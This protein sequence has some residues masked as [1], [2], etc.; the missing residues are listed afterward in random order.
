MFALKDFQ[1]EAIDQ[2]SNTFLELWKTGNYKI[3]L[4]FKAPTGA[5][6]TIMMAEFLRCLDDNYHFHEGKAYI[7]I[8]F[9]GDDSYAQSKKKLYYYYNEGTAMNLKDKN[10]LSEGKLYKNNIFFINWSKIKGTDKESKKLR[11]PNEHTEGEFGVFDEYI[12]KTKKDGREIVLIIDEAH[13]ETDTTLAN[14]V[15][16]LL[17]HQK[18]CQILAMYHRKKQVLLRF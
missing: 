10:N 8:S 6:K 3:P 16:D 12:Q 9:G 2:L 15:I 18:I 14:E 17:E 5:G 1:A 13:T 4:V 11:K 7:W